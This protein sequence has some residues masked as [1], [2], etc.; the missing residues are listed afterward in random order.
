MPATIG[1]NIEIHVSLFIPS[2]ICHCVEMTHSKLWNAG[3]NWWKLWD[4]GAGL[5]IFFML[6]PFG[7]GLVFCLFYMSAPFNC[8]LCYGTNIKTI[9]RFLT[10][11]FGPEANI[12]FLIPMMS[13]WLQH[14]LHF[15]NVKHLGLGKILEIEKQFVLDNK[16]QSICRKGLSAEYFNITISLWISSKWSNL[17][18]ISLQITNMCLIKRFTISEVVLPNVLSNGRTT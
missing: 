1:K 15:T 12:A 7:G 17:P 16:S 2:A 13:V 14:W 4:C 11:L 6:G 5:W 10:Y 3:L 8:N 9:R 18:Y